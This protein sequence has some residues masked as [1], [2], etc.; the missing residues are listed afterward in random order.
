MFAAGLLAERGADAVKVEQPGTGESLRE[1]GLKANGRD[2][3]AVDS[4][5]ASLERTSSEETC[6]QGQRTGTMRVGRP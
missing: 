4:K 2:R 6:G 3:V 5:Q 1:L